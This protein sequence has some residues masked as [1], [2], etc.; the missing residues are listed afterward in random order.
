MVNYRFDITNPSG[1]V[2]DTNNAI[3]IDINTPALDGEYIE[4]D[5]QIVQYLVRYDNQPEYFVIKEWNKNNSADAAAIAAYNAGGALSFRFYNDANISALSSADSVKPYDSVPLLSETLEL[6]L[7]RL[8]LGN[9]KIGYDTPSTTSLT[10]T[11]LAASLTN[12]PTVAEAIANLH[13]IPRLGTADDIAALACFLLSSDSSWLTG[14]ILH[15]DGG[16]S[17]LRPKG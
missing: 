11:P 2:S 5:V 10:A 12:N 17:T 13:P 8:F 4:Q 1:V 6:G 9:N 3:D 14:Q 7:N 16:R 15:V